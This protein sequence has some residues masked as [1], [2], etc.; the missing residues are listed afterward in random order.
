MKKNCFKD[1]AKIYLQDQF[2]LNYKDYNFVSAIECERAG[3]ALADQIINAEKLLLTTQ[4]ERA[5]S[6]RSSMCLAIY[7]FEDCINNID[8]DAEDDLNEAEDDIDKAKKALDRAERD[9]D[10]A[11]NREERGRSKEAIDRAEDDLD[12]AKDDYREARRD[13]ETDLNNADIDFKNCL[14]FMKDI[15]KEL[16]SRHGG[17][18][19]KSKSDADYIRQQRAFLDNRANFQKCFNNTSRG[20][21][22]LKKCIKK[23]MIKGMK[24]IA[25]CS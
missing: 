23:D 8:E 16:E 13:Y 18:F 9:Y 1:K 10:R 21:G 20:P 11:D 14:Y 15:G 19:E 22:D 3:L 24:E 4:D 25:E 17:A 6:Q 7:E 2:C 5:E 12:E